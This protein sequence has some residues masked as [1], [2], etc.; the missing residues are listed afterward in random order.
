MVKKGK[1]AGD[2]SMSDEAPDNNANNYGR[3]DRDVSNSNIDTRSSSIESNN[4][5]KGNNSDFNNYRDRD[6][7]NTQA[8]RAEA[9]SAFAADENRSAVIIK[10]HLFGVPPP[11]DRRIFEDMSGMF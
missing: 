3:N 4:D 8:A 5:S 6:A 7:K 2:A 11:D 10:R 1:T 9:K